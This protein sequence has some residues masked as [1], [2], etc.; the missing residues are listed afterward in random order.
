MPHV[1][2]RHASR[3]ASTGLEKLEHRDASAGPRHAAHLVESARNVGQVAHPEGDRDGIET[4]VRKWN[5]FRASLAEAEGA[6]RHL[7][8][9]LSPGDIEHASR[10]VQSHHHHAGRDAQ[11]LAGAI[12][13]LSRAERPAVITL[14]A[15]L[16][17]PA[18]LVEIARER[19]A[20]LWQTPYGSALAGI[21]AACR[22][23]GRGAGAI[24]AVRETAGGWCARLLRL[25]PPDMPSLPPRF[26]GGLSFDPQA[27]RDDAWR[28]FPDA[29]F[30]LPR[31]TY[32]RD[33]S[34]AFL[35]LALAG[36][37][38][39]RAGDYLEEFEALAHALELDPDPPVLDTGEIQV[40][41][42]D[43][44]AW[45]AHVARTRD[46]IR[47]GR[48]RKVVAARASVVE[49]ERDMDPFALISRVAAEHVGSTAFAI[50]PG[51]GATFLGATPETLIS[52]SGLRVASDPLAGSIAL[53]DAAGGAAE[54]E[55]RAA[56]LLASRKDAAEHALV[57][58]SVTAL[59]RPLVHALDFPGTPRIRADRHVMHLHTP[60]RGELLAARHV[61]ELVAALHP[62]PSVGGVPTSDALDWI[63]RF[64]PGSRGWYAG[65]VGW[66]DT[67][68]NGEF[69][70][71][72]RCGL[73]DGTTA[74]VHAGAG[75]VADSD[76]AAEYEET[77]VKQRPFL[78][79]LGIA[80]PVAS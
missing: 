78:R 16:A 10:R 62:T 51:D 44:D 40:T 56:A 43:P 29:L 75:I 68:G 77:V 27:P 53:P 4:P 13:H 74:L 59:L 61:L 71:A 8:I 49:S 35:R 64:E 17:R 50:A 18:A 45:R 48:F 65:P 24:H 23:E 37:P 33:G 57:V 31:W 72:I 60:I 42:P 47:E 41:E 36:S 12:A 80:V 39:R 66:F 58:E 79:A 52:V 9:E 34:R 7:T 3:R 11:D 5:R 38:S 76:P 21:G 67:A 19:P 28:E 22:I 14:P 15:P 32:E 70:I 46:A 26:F 20:I 25:A 2:A 6:A 1:K 69:A 30:V 73:V 63:R 55:R 54:R